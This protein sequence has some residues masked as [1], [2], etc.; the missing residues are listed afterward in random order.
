M[1]QIKNII[2]VIIIFMVVSII[3]AAFLMII[4]QGIDRS[5]RSD[6]LKWQHEATQY[7]HFYLTEWQANQCDSLHIKINA[8]TT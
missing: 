6:C 2:D 8:P 3:V 7:K 5:D 4:V 1:N